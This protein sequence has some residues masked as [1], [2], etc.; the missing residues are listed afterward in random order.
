M[1]FSSLVRYGQR[2][3]F[4][5]QTVAIAVSAPSIDCPGAR[6]LLSA[7]VRQFTAPPVVKSSAPVTA[8]SA[9][10]V[11][12]LW[13]EGNLFALSIPELTAFLKAQKVP[14]IDPTW[15]KSTLV[16]QV[17]EIVSS[18]RSLS[19]RS[20]KGS[21]I[22][23]RSGDELSASDKLGDLTTEGV[24][25]SASSFVDVQQSGLYSGSDSMGPII[26][27]AFQ[28]MHASLAPDV[29][30]SRINTSL[31]PGGSATLQAYTFLPTS[32]ANS[33]RA[34]FSKAFQWC[35]LNLWNMSMDGEMHVSLGRLLFWKGS[36]CYSTDAKTAEPR[37]MT[38]WSAQQQLQAH[39]P[40]TWLSIASEKNRADLEEYLTQNAYKR[41]DPGDEP[42]TSYRVSVK[43]QNR[44]ILEGE[45]DSD[46]CTT[47]L[48]PCWER[49]LLTFYVRDEMPD[50]RIQL[51]ARLPLKKKTGDMF[52]GV[53]LVKAAR[54]E[55]HV[56]PA[57]PGDLGEV[58]FA[59]KRSVRTWKRTID[60]L[61]ISLLISE[62][63]SS[64]AYSANPKN[65]TDE[66][67]LEYEIRCMVPQQTD[68]VDL[69]AIS[70]EV[71]DTVLGFSKVM[72]QGMRVFDCSP[73]SP[74]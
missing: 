1:R 37:F 60:S 24:F 6:P 20:V 12:E 27:R 46:H 58:V 66:T 4:S 43:R 69:G 3:F 62:V 2:K 23:K 11:W 7:H 35:V 64:V 74:A 55:A 73:V 47:S 41:T 72:E 45:V 67:R 68:N 61:R 44:E 14:H 42:V 71:W 54:N 21:E 22:A 16:K 18:M 25:D 53:K 48:K 33:N 56:A 34:R 57:I 40:Y 5:S 70:E 50:V 31:F 15:R 26:P 52:S 19:T 28:L 63:S 9:D 51:R 30:L 10:R 36:N 32:A 8:P 65:M 17:E 49:F 39:Q 29:V 38:L 13:S 59:T